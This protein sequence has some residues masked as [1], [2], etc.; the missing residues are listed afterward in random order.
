MADTIAVVNLLRF[1]QPASDTDT[2]TCSGFD[3]S[4]NGGIQIESSGFNMED[5]TIT[6]KG[7][8]G[9]SKV[10]EAASGVGEICLIGSEGFSIAS[11]Q[12]TGIAAGMYSVK[13]TQN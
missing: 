7:E 3:L 10:V 6:A 2:L 4:K 13:F 11:I 5:A 1:W 12:I 9:A 8:T